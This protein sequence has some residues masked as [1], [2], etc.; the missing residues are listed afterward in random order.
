MIA[1]PDKAKSDE[2]SHQKA[3][4]LSQKNVARDIL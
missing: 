1:H 2:V 4:K 3:K